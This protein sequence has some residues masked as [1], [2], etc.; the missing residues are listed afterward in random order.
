MWFF[1]IKTRKRKTV[2]PS[3]SKHKEQ[4]RALIVSKLEYWAPICEVSFKRVAIRNTKRCWGSCS[5]LGNLNFSYKMLFLPECLADYIIIHELCHL[6]ELNHSPKFWAEV[7]KI[8]PH[9]RELVLELR[10]LEK[11][12]RTN[13]ESMRQHQNTH[14]CQHCQK[15]PFFTNSDPY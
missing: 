4:T 10:K 15:V 5:S 8:M 2:N 6:K 3:Y 9:Y 1:K 14:S 13:V 11:S 12:T 7:E